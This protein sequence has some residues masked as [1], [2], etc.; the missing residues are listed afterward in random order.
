MSAHVIANIAEPTYEKGQIKFKPALSRPG[1]LKSKM[2]SHNKA[3]SVRSTKNSH[4]K[5]S[6][7]VTL[8]AENISLNRIGDNPSNV[9][10]CGRKGTKKIK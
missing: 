1:S 8:D 7:R 10:L 5:A 9:D 2:I 6:I 3:K 4:K